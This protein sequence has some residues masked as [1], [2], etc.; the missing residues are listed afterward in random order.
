MS[1]YVPRKPT[2]Y[3]PLEGI[4]EP[5]SIR[6][7]S[8]LNTYDPYSI[9]D[10]QLTDMSNMSTSDYP[11]LS[12]R[13][14]YSV[15]GTF[16]TRVLGLGAWKSELHAV[17]NDGSWRKWNGSTWTTLLTGLDT[18]AEWSFTVFQGNLDDINLI[19]ANGAV[20]K[21]YDGSTVVDLSGAPAGL[22][23]ITTYSNRLW[24]AVGKELHAC[25]LD[26]PESWSDFSGTDEDSYVKDMESTRGEDINF[27]SGSLSRM[28]IGMKNSIHELYGD[29][30]SNFQVKLIVDNIGIIN[31]KASATQEGIM[32]IIDERTIYDYA[33]GNLPNAEFSQIVGKY[34]AALDT[35]V[36]AGA[37]P[38]RLYFRTHSGEIM[39][40]D[41]RTGVGAW[42]RWGNIDP[43][44]FYLLDD[45]MY[46]GDSLGRVLK[47]DTSTNDAG[48]PISWSFTTKPF[49]N[50]TMSRRQRWLKMWMYAEIPTGTTIN[51][52]L[53]TSKDGNDFNL[54]HTAAGTGSGVERIIIPVRSVVLE[55]TVRVK[56]SGT[57]PAKIHELVRQVR[58]LS[59]F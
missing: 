48:T 15:L 40:Y 36:S 11:A 21:R 5:I 26:Q 35:N 13:A 14:G 3:Q 16:G 37:D 52:Y 34:L 6:Q 10:S 47:L 25:A 27:L 19:G 2:E 24:G 41:S 51:V 38:D 20:T 59:L 33:G 44:F 58:Q 49:T 50:P 54:V 57:G 8:G 29:L 1:N 42:S 30:P 7:W 17:F 39:V 43:T 23:Y 55:N 32:R 28:T 9:S 4:Q 46:I 45:V 53:S 18:A 22:K 56:I 31:N 12:V